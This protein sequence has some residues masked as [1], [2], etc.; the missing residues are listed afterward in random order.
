MTQLSH[1]AD[2]CYLP[3]RG[4]ASNFS[5]TSVIHVR[6]ATRDSREITMMPR[7]NGSDPDTFGAFEDV[8]NCDR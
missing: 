8:D 5:Q 6:S 1:A 7:M 2:M 3:N 4:A